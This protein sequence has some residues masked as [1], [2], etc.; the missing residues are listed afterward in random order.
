MAL[1]HDDETPHLAHPGSTSTIV[2]F[3]AALREA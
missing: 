2:E 1:H 3:A